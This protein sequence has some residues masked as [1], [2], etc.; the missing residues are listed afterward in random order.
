MENISYVGLS[1]QLALQQ[2][3]DVTAN[4]LAN[5][6]TSGFKTQNV[7]FTD[8]LSKAKA[9]DQVNQALNFGSY[10]DLSSGTMSQTH[11]NLDVAIEG[12]GFF[13]VQT[14]S[15]TQYTRD[16]GFA[17]NANRELVTKSGYKVIGDGG[18]ITFPE[19]ARTITI[20]ADG[21]VSSE[22]GALGHL[23][24]VDF[25]NP[26]KLKAVGS[27]LFDANGAAEKPVEGL[28]VVQGALE[29]SNVNPIVEMNKMVDILRNFQAVQRM[30]QTDHE[31]MTDM[32]QKMTKV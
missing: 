22:A 17:L 19:D 31:R 24:I 15:G 9:G 3:M 25:D 7:L 6:N 29:G 21:E 28:R 13:A 10:R 1:Q 26:Q 12:T 20:T 23:K 27:N 4:N 18:P 2:Q 8:Y 32:I 14:P 30:L 5:M 16:G 11:N